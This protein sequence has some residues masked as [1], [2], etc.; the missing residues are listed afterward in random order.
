TQKAISEVTKDRDLMERSRETKHLDGSHAILL[1]H[2][3]TIACGARFRRHH[4]E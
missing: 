2:P 1:H 4:I 3:H